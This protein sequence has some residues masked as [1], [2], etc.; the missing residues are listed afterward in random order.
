MAF[1]VQSQ[2]SINDISTDTIDL[3]SRAQLSSSAKPMAPSLISTLLLPGS[4]HQG[5]GRSKSA[6]AYISIDAA[7]LFSAIFFN[8]FAE[9]TT[10]DAKAFAALFAKAPADLKDDYYWQIVGAF[11]S[12]ADFQEAVQLNRVSDEKFG[13]ESFIW[14]WDHKS[15]RDEFVSMQ[16]NAK[17]YGMISSF[18]VGAM[19]LNRIIS[20][21][22]VR[23]ALKSNRYNG[24]AAISIAPYSSGF[25]A[26]GLVVR[27]NF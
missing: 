19:V 23:T 25:S 2:I 16:K 14:R 27:S 26:N 11:D 22:D 7:V 8:R 4:A 6:L 17:R 18:C 21:I 1:Q 5:L 9:K 12:Y 13:D 3:F 15:Y 24:K 10:S 20:F